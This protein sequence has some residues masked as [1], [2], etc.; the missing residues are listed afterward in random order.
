[1]TEPCHWGQAPPCG[2]Q[3]SRGRAAGDGCSARGRPRT[4]CGRSAGIGHGRWPTTPLAGVGHRPALPVIHRPAAGLR[5]AGCGGRSGPIR[6]RRPGSVIGRRA[7]QAVSPARTARYTSRLSAALLGQVRLGPVQ[8]ALAGPRRCLRRRAT[9]APQSFSRRAPRTP[10]PRPATRRRSRSVA[11]PGPDLLHRPTLGQPRD[12]HGNLDD[13][14]PP[15]TAGR[16]RQAPA[17]GSPDVEDGRLR[18]SPAGS[19]PAVHH[20]PR[21]REPGAV[22]WGRARD[23]RRRGD[24]E[25]N[26]RL[27]ERPRAEGPPTP[28]VPAALSGPLLSSEA[29][30]VSVRPAGAYPYPAASRPAGNGRTRRRPPDRKPAP[31]SGR[32]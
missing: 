32:Q 19:L 4:R 17:D 12:R 24:G 26:G 11:E 23:S 10:R 20:G 30:T 15:C 18:H 14:P 31:L 2:G 8:A 16:R 25:Q 13:V 27:N 9:S 7:G 3:A 21:Y 29:D 5:R 28:R 1:M 22:V 6:W